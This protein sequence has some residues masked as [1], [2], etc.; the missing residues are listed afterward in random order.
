MTAGPESKGRI[1]C[2]PNAEY[3]QYLGVADEL[4]LNGRIPRVGDP[5]A[6]AGREPA[7]LVSDELDVPA[8]AP[9][10]PRLI[11]VT[12]TGNMSGQIWPVRELAAV[13]R[14]HRDCPAQDV[15]GAALVPGR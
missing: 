9:A 6:L 12:G 3:V 4:I 1:P 15:G 14:R 10:A 11:A 2:F 5:L 13:A 8:D 7:A